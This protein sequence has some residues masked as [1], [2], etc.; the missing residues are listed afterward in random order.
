M[1]VNG[2]F[3]PTLDIAQGEVQR[4]RICNA[5]SVFYRLRLAGRQMFVVNI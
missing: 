2:Q 1:L 4:W 3:Q 5:S